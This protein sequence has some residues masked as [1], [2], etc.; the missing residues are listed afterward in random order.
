MVSLYF[1]KRK[2]LALSAWNGTSQLGDFIS[3]ITFFIIVASR[4]WQPYS[5]FFL[6][7]FYLLV[8]LICAIVFI[9]K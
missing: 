8:L 7:S 1:D 9:P 4:Q 2:G 3:L 6:A 5:S